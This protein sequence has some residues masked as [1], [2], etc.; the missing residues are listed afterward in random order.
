[1]NVS[2][3]WEF[4]LIIFVPK[5]PHV[6]NYL[7]GVSVNC[8]TVKKIELHVSDDSLE[9][10]QVCTQYAPASHSSEL[11]GQMIRRAQNL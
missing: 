1:M 2:C 4:L 10:W 7:K 11:S 6:S 9:F 8:V 3:Y 5:S